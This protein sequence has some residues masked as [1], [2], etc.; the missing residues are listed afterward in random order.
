MDYDERRASG[1]EWTVVM[2]LVLMFAFLSLFILPQGICISE[3]IA[4]NMYMGFSSI[5]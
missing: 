4:S 3:A 5:N 1:V 2:Y